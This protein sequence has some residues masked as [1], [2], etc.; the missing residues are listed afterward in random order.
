M[1]SNIYRTIYSK[2]VQL[3]G[4]PKTLPIYRKG[5]AEGE[6]DLHVERLLVGGEAMMVSLAHYIDESETDDPVP[7]P[8][9][10]V[11]V[12]TVREEAKMVNY[13]DRATFR[14]AHPS[15]GK[16]DTAVEQ[17]L[18]AF[19]DQWLEQLVEREYTFVEVDLEKR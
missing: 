19:L 2:L 14:T 13:Q 15:P 7:D 12:Y 8:L 17:D 11:K 3:I 5:K 4:D 1:S 9:M 6:M 18:N 16:V 10:E